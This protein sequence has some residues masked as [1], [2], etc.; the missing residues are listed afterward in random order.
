[1]LLDAHANRM[2][3][4]GVESIRETLYHCAGKQKKSIP[5]MDKE[6]SVIV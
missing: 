5:Q 1:M 4:E 3:S 6:G 2:V